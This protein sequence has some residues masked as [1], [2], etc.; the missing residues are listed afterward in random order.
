MVFLPSG[1]FLAAGNMHGN[2]KVWDLQTK[3]A[4][5]R[6]FKSNGWS[7][8]IACSSDGQLLAHSTSTG[9]IY[10]W[11]LGSE[12]CLLKLKTEWKV[13]ELSFSSDGRSLMTDHGGLVPEYWPSHIETRGGSIKEIMTRMKPWTYRFSFKATESVLMVLG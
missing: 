11:D 9:E 5:E 7:V 8:G 6:K 13:G 1:R 10:L 4:E 3:D 12:S 2:V